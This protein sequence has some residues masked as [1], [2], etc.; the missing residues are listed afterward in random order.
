MMPV[1]EDG[2]SPYRIQGAGSPTDSDPEEEA[3]VLQLSAW[4]RIM[5]PF[6]WESPPPA[7]PPWLLRLRSIWELEPWVSVRRGEGLNG[8]S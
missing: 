3:P 8:T 6:I 7:P 4:Y 1:S 5:E 2:I